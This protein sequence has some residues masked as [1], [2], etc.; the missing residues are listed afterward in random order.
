MAGF[1]CALPLISGLI[2]SCGAGAPLATGYVEGDYVLMAP[3]DVA[4]VETI[5]VRRGDRVRAGASLAAMETQDAEIAAQLATAALGQARAQLAN[6]QEG[7][8]PEEV[9]VIQ[10]N[11]VSAQAQAEDAKRTFDR[12]SDLLKRGIAPQSDY[13]KA[14]TALDL[15][16]AAVA[17]ANANLAVAQLPARQ[18]EIDAAKDA[19]KQAEASLDQAKWKLGKRN[20]VAPADGI[21]QDI[22][23]RQGEVAGPSQPVL[24]VLPDGAVKLR[25][26][27]PEK[28]VSRLKVGSTLAVNCDG[29][30]AGIKARVSY[31][32]DGP[33][34]TPPVI[35]SL[36]NRQKLVYMIEAQPEG[37]ADGLKPGQIVDVRLADAQGAGAS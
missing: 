35:Y 18:Q 36:E 30:E 31:I 10:A 9:A 3:L 28:D 24:S 12:Q 23:R 1:L 13:D 14:K 32:A 22:I 34:F 27:I 7:R 6:L 5:A 37:S 29:C 26:Y 21:V 8:R 20:L 16:T 4:R 11:L 15:A 33:E 17:Q 2:A 19:V 25:I